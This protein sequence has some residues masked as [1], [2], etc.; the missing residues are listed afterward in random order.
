MKRIGILTAGGDTPALN[1]TIH[2]AVVRANQLKIE[3]YGFIKGFNALFNPRVPH[4]HLNPLFQGIPEVDP[5]KGG[6]LIGSSRDFVDPEKKDDLDRIARRLSK[7]GIDGLICIGGDGTLNGLQPLAERLPTVLAPKTIDNDLGLNYPSEPDEWM[8]EKDPTAHHG[9]RYKRGTPDVSFDLDQMVNYATPGYATA[10]MVTAQGIE[11]VR[12]TAESHRRIAIIEVMGRHAGYIA[13]GTAYGKPDI[14]LVPESPLNLDLLVDRVKH[15]YDLQ[16]NVVI[17]C[18]EGIVDENGVELG[19]VHS[20]VDP[21]GNVSLSGAAE[22]LRSKLIERLGDRYFQLYRRGNSAKE[23][24]FI[25]KVG[26]TQR[27]GRPI[28]FDRFYA[29]LLGSKAVDLLVE[30]HNNAVSVL[31]YQAGKGFHVEGYDANRFRDRWG[32]IHARNMHTAFY[33]PKWMRPSRIGIDYLLPI[34]TGA[35]GN[36][37]AE[38]Y[39]QTVF[40]AGNLAQPYHSVNTDVNKRIRHLEAND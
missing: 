3:L 18:G 22:A 36:D 17:V 16:K 19:A 12:T 23:A 5:T 31:Q 4:V 20:S 21:A 38:Y 26:H 2:G 15:L 13:L 34:F 39:R 29:A 7:L 1:A 28:L 9:F 37:D 32:L 8:Q 35:I 10:V 25:R 27:G 40:D 11:R 6:T 24:I 14:I 30:G 33:D